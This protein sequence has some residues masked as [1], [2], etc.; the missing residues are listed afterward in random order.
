MSKT[1]NLT[2]YA[3][4]EKITE[5]DGSFDCKSENYYQDKYV[6][7]YDKEAVEMQEVTYGQ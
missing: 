1:K 3:L 6:S 2:N 7:L 4:R 5:S